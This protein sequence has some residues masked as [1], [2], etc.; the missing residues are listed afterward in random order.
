MFFVLDIIA[1]LLFLLSVVSCHHKGFFKSFFGMLK[2]VIA[3][4]ASYIFMPT[5]A[6][7]YRTNFVE[8][9]ISDNVAS[10]INSIARRTAEGFNLE[11]LFNDMPSEFAD[12]LERYGADTQKLSEK[13]GSLTDAAE[14]SV[15]ELASSITSSVVRT[16]SDI[17]AFATLFIGALIILTVVI[18]I[19]GMIVQLPVL[20]A[21]DKG[22]GV[23]FGIISG[24]LI[25]WVYCNLVCI[26][27]DALRAVKP[28]IIGSNVIENTY[29]VKYICD[30][31][32]FGF[33]AP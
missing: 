8:K 15:S 33:A 22:L 12:I 17:L 23:A 3:I 5:V 2:V 7:F 31:F 27:V 30:N 24:L 20:S 16:V 21:I 19:I 9:L 13:F 18:W 6:Y 14:E 26:G 28:G 29:I 4:I 25:V 11:K 1:V 32:S 10:R